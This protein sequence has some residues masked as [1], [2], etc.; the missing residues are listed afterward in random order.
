MK[1]QPPPRAPRGP[2]AARLISGLMR[3]HFVNIPDIIFR[4][5][6]SFIL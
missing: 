2:R 6:A 1:T 4:Y 3:Y 5:I